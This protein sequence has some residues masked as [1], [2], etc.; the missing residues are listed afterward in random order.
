M[1][2]DP[3]LCRR[4]RMSLGGTDSNTLLS[5]HVRLLGVRGPEHTVTSI[6]IATC[7]DPLILR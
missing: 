2:F 3:V 7:A 1:T 5:R 6:Y 4:N